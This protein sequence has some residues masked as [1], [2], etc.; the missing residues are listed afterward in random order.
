MYCFDAAMRYFIFG[1]KTKLTKLAGY[2]GVWRIS[3]W[4]E[5]E[6]KRIFSTFDRQ[7][8]SVIR[9]CCYVV[10]GF[11][12]RDVWRCLRCCKRGNGHAGLLVGFV[13]ICS[14]VVAG[15]GF[16]LAWI[17]LHQEDIRPH[18]PTIA[19][20]CNGL[21]VIFYLMLY[22][23]GPSFDLCLHQTFYCRKENH[24][25]WQFIFLMRKKKN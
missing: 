1:T 24:Y 4:R 20:I 7:A 10:G 6:G 3:T 23:W 2:L 22:I 17:S 18:F 12:G 5:K 9:H 8:S 25:V 16:V 11:V 21:L 13:G 19:S 15:V 14:L